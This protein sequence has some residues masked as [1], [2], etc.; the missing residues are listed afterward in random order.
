[1][2]IKLVPETVHYIKFQIKICFESFVST[3]DLY[4]LC[5]INWNTTLNYWFINSVRGNFI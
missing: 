3:Y 5:E 1:M 2:Y 4:H